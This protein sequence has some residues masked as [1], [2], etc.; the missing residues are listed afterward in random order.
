MARQRRSIGA[1]APS[2]PPRVRVR[3][4]VKLSATFFYDESS[5]TKRWGGDTKVQ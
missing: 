2:Y 5:I 4:T 1:I 3:A